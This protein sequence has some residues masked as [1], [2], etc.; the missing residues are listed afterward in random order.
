[1]ID[2]LRL[3]FATD[4]KMPS[5]EV[6]S[7]RGFDLH[8]G[9]RGQWIRATF[10][11]SYA[12]YVTWSNFERGGA[13][14]TV[15]ASLANLWTRKTGQR[16]FDAGAITLALNE[17]AAKVVEITGIRCFDPLSANVARIDYFADFIVGEGNVERYVAAVL[18][19]TP[20]R[21]KPIRWG[22]TTAYFR[23]RGSGR[24]ISFYGKYADALEKR[25][26]RRIFE[27]NPD[28]WLGV[29]RLETRF[30]DSKTCA[31]LAKRMG[32][33]D[34]CAHNL[35]TRNIWESV[36][37]DALRALNLD[38]DTPARDERARILLEV[39]PK[40]APE[41]FGL[42]LYRELFGDDCRK[43]FRWSP[44]TFRR[45]RQLLMTS[46]LWTSAPAAESLPCLR[47]VP[48]PFN[49]PKSA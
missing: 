6:L 48:P 19:S 33:P 29:V 37:N 2:T 38:R 23:T 44:K 34:N 25:K 8:L 47:L 12:P 20:P 39:Y 42:L 31:R 32:V 41:L 7:G 10:K 35:L 43:L 27:S 26:R 9:A 11:S 4:T 5:P 1:M 24:E 40:N 49:L 18:Q 14:L 13:K 3:S 21:F 16:E 28:D 46:S 36:M 30:R 45:K 22:A 17:L 15:Q